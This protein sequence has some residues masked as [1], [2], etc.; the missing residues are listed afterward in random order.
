MSLATRLSLFFLS[1]L[2]AVLICFSLALWF[3]QD[4]M[5]LRHADGILVGALDTLVASIEIEPDGV[6]WNPSEHRFEGLGDRSAS[7]QWRVTSGAGVVIDQSAKFQPLV[8]TTEAW[9][10]REIATVYSKDGQAWRIIVEHVTVPEH[11]GDRDESPVDSDEVPDV[12]E[13]SELIIVAAISM[14][15]DHATMRQLAL[16]LAVLSIIVWLLAA[17]FG[18]GL[19]RHALRPL[20]VM[21]NA[22]SRIDEAGKERL[23][24]AKTGDEIEELGRRFNELLDRLQ[25]AFERERRF[26]A[27]ASHQLRTPVTILL[28]QVDVALRRDRSETEY[29][30]TL[31]EVRRQSE[32]LRTIIESLLSLARSESRPLERKWIE[33]S[34]WLPRHVEEF[35]ADS[36][37]GDLCVDLAGQESTRVATAADLLGQLLDILMDNAL[38]Y[39]PAGTPVTVRLSREGDGLAIDVIDFGPGI[40]EADVADMFRPF[41]RGADAI[42]AGVPGLGLGLA[43][44]RRI[45]SRLGA[46][47]EYSPIETG[48]SRFR[49]RFREDQSERPGP[50]IVEAL[51]VALVD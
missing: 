5:L 2:A 13:Y 19:A 30:E 44:A 4:W 25:S 34:R 29:R 38:K 12:P 18:G 40:P 15:G 32:R 46:S 22:A 1:L 17:V 16:A 41:H 27:E 26:T 7:V 50:A 49:I 36:R 48:G 42:H 6:E 9:A 20:V 28:G 39:S 31:G 37:A 14:S 11:D 8:K 24:V 43:L 23:P 35:A 51:P 10:D 47:L 21:S 45:A 33:L 3:I